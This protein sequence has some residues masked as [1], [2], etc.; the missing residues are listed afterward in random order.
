MQAMESREREEVELDAFAEWSTTYESCGRVLRG[1]F[2]AP[3]GAGPF[4]G[5][6]FHHGSGGLLAAAR[7]GVEALV[8]MGYAVFVAVRRGHNGNPGPYWESLITAPWGTPEMGSQLVSAL[9][10]ECDDAVAALEWLRTAPSVDSDRTAMIGSSYGGVMVMLAAGRGA[11]F[12]AGISFAGPSIT[13]PD[14]PALQATL[15]ESLRHTEVPLMLIQAGDD[16]HLTPTYVLGAEL[17]LLGKPHETRIYQ[18][19]GAQRG[20]GHGVFNKAVSLWKPDVER[21]LARVLET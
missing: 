5:I 7:P 19:I 8:A 17:A 4:P 13:W 21:F 18:P 12:L 16:F 15:L 1:F 2:L 20:D 9:S 10:D 11:P 3:P 14:A 6:V